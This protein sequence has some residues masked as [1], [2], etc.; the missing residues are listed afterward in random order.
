[1][2][3]GTDDRPEKQHRLGNLENQTYSSTVNPDSRHTY[4]T[5][6]TDIFT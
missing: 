2:I 4:L 5:R 1:M 3:Q 6:E